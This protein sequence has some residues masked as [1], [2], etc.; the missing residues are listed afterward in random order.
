[1]FSERWVPAYGGWCAW[2]MAD[3]EPVDVDPER[4]L[5]DDGRLFL[6]YDG[7]WGDTLVRWR[8]GDP[9]L[10]ER[11]ADAHWRSLSVT[12]RSQAAM[13]TE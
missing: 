7:L 8:A 3:G 12:R 6:F 5:V 11:R 9:A 13:K 4:F 10:L 2:A 1:M